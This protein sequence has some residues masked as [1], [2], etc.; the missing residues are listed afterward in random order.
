MVLASDEILTDDSHTDVE[1][2]FRSWGGSRFRPA[3]PGLMLYSQDDKQVAD[4]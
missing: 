3:G 1:D 4:K 2:P